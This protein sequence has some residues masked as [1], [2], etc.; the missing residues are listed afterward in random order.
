MSSPTVDLTLYQPDPT[1]LPP[2][3]TQ[4]PARVGLGSHEL[5]QIAEHVQNL[6]HGQSAAIAGV[7][8]SARRQGP[9]TGEMLMLQ[10]AVSDYS[11][12]LQTL[13]HLAQSAGSAIQSLTQRT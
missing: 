13:S 6:V 11:I 10:A 12:T 1:V 8:D 3:P 2:P 7:L 5:T 4:E 9:T